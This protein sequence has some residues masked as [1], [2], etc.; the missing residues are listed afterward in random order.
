VSLKTGKRKILQRGG[1][2][3]RYLPSGHLVYLHQGGL[4]G[5]TF[6]PARLELRGT[7]APLLDA[8]AANAVS[9][10]GQFDFSR[11]GTFVYL[12]G[13]MATRAWPVV[14]LGRSGKTQPLM[15]TPRAY[16]FPRFSPDGQRLALAAASDKGT[17]LFVHEWQRD[18]MMQLTFGAQAYVPVWTPDGK[19]ITFGSTSAG[20]AL[21]WIRSDGAGTAERLLE[22]HNNVVPYSFSPDGLRLA[23]ME[24]SPKTG[25]DIWTLPLDTSDP[26]HPK[27]GKPEPFLRTSADERV[28]AFSPDGHWIAYRSDESGRSEIYVLPFPGGGGKWQISTGG[29]LYGIWSN[30]GREL[31]YEALDNRIMVVDYTVNGDSF[32]PGKPRLWSN[33]QIFNPGAGNLALAPDGKRFAVFPMPEP[34]PGDKSPVHVTFLLNFFDE[35]K[36]RLPPG[37]K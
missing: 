8:V 5:V 35:L 31:F 15:A 34:T 22:S 10:R 18:T 33:K 36:R 7:P 24:I 9:G 1:Y 16:Y 20:Y 13:K 37:G 19:H 17:D 3:G 6:D 28:P 27:P 11:T 14:W 4:F 29:G 32:V 25:F 23:Y 30:N 12:A 21:S 26:D 2:F